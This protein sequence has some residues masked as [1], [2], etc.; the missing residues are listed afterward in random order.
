MLFETSCILVY[1]L[2]ISK[3]QCHW[4]IKWA[5]A[6]TMQKK[7]R[8]SVQHKCVHFAIYLPTLTH[9]TMYSKTHISYL[10]T[11]FAVYWHRL[12]GTRSNCKFFAEHER[13][14]RIWLSVVT[15]SR[16]FKYRFTSFNYIQSGARL[17]ISWTW[18]IPNRQNQWKTFFYS[19]AT[20]SSRSPPSSPGYKHNTEEEVKN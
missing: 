20:C 18:Q 14:I 8:G 5:G 3:A 9:Y 2:A 16:F 17:G 19:T 13:F 1:L 11:R 12:Q 6:T 10:P 15:R 4:F 7:L